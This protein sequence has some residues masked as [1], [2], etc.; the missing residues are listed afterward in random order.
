MKRL[1]L[2]FSVAWLLSVSTAGAQ[3]P[4]QPAPEPVAEIGPSVNPETSPFKYRQDIP[5]SALAVRMNAAY[6][7]SQRRGRI[8]TR[9]ANGYSLSRPGA[10]VTPFVGGDYSTE[11]APSGVCDDPWL[12]PAPVVQPAPSLSVSQRHVKTKLR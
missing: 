10:N 5:D 7:G 3:E 2:S 8:E 9:K 6:K 11:Y 1:V 12:R 4:V